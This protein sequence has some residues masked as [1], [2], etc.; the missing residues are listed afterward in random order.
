M[1]NS[2]TMQVLKKSS[3]NA[4]VGAESARLHFDGRNGKERNRNRKVDVSSPPGT[5]TG[6]VSVA[7][8]VYRTTDAVGLRSFGSLYSEGVDSSSLASC[9]C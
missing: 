8:Y 3:T 5:H 1:L 4:Y 2:S 7:T 9:L 6:L